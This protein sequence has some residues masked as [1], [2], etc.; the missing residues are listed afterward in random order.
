MELGFKSTH[1][2]LARLLLGGAS[3]PPTVFWCKLDLSKGRSC[4]GFREENARVLVTRSANN[5]READEMRKGTL[6][7]TSVLN[8][9]A[10][11]FCC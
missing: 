6:L 11:D 2:G 9:V 3:P 7:S 8:N 1:L 10:V 5:P 4:L